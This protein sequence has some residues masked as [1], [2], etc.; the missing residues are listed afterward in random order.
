MLVES[1]PNFLAE[2]GKTFWQRAQASFIKIADE[3][4][5]RVIRKSNSN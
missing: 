3:P 4:N 5:F 1:R 2:N